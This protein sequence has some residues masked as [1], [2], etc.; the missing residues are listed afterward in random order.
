MVDDE[1]WKAGEGDMES[2]GTFYNS[3]KT[4]SPSLVWWE[5]DRE[6][7][8]FRRL[9]RTFVHLLF[10]HALVLAI[11][12]P[13]TCLQTHCLFDYDVSLLARGGNSFMCS[14]HGGR[15]SNP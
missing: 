12:V 1:I 13:A 6:G 15:D 2:F 14:V 10:P 4:R 11:S 3:E 5:E 7:D 8:R 9:V